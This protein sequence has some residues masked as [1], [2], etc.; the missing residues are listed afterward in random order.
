VARRAEG[1]V[2]QQQRRPER[3]ALLV[4]VG[5]PQPH[6]GKPWLEEPEG[7]AGEA[8]LLQWHAAAEVEG[9]CVVVGVPAP[10]LLSRG[11][12]CVGVAADVVAVDCLGECR[13]LC[14]C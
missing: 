7:G 3:G 8:V 14:R 1:V 6:G 2:R 12:Q 10:R 4:G 5:A 11:A 9:R 13:E